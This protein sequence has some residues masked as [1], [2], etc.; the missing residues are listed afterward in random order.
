MSIRDRID[1]EL[2]RIQ[3]LRD[4]IDVQA[5]LAKIEAQDELN[6][7]WKKAEHARAKLEAEFERIKDGAEEPLENIGDAAE[8]LID[9]IKTGY[10][11]LKELI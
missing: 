1:Q 7:L 10:N 5:H 3:A 11:K 9:E 6:A 2:D 4:E 8:V